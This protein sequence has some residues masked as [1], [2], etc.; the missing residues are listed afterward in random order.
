MTTDN[1]TLSVVVSQPTSIVPSYFFCNLILT[2][3]DGSSATLS[4]FTYG[5]SGTSSNPTAWVESASTFNI[6][7]FGHALAGS[8]LSSSS[9]ILYALGGV[10]ASQNV[11]SSVEYATASEVGSLS[12]WTLDRQPLPVG[13][14][15][16][17][18][19]ALDQFVYVLGGAPGSGTSRTEVL[20]AQILSALA[21]PSF[22]SV[23]FG[24]NV[25]ANQTFASG[26]F[27]YQVSAAFDGNYVRNPNGETLPSQSASFNVPNLDFAIRITLSWSAVPGAASYRIYRS[28]F[29][30]AN[31]SS[32]Y[33]LA[34]VPGNV[35]QYSDNG[36]VPVN[37]AF[38]PKIPGEL[39]NWHLTQS[40]VTSRFREGC[41]I[42]PAPNN[43]GTGSQYFIYA[44]GG[45]SSASSAVNTIEFASISIIAPTTLT[46]STDQVVGSFSVAATTM[47]SAR[48]N[49][50]MIAG[51]R[52]EFSTVPANAV[53]FWIGGGSTNPAAP[54]SSQSNDRDTSSDTFLISSSGVPQAATVAGASFPWGYCIAK[55]GDRFRISGGGS[56]QGGACSSTTSAAVAAD[57]TYSA[58]NDPSAGLVRCRRY[59]S[60]QRVG[61]FVFNCAGFNGVTPSQ[62]W[63]TCELN[64]F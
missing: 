36:T 23:D 44:A 8:K 33:L 5:T 49:I 18:A 59:S 61:A 14:Q 34:V 27:S 21:V 3:P 11:I 55:G 63:N 28:P 64:F 17:C 41:V 37:F 12:T 32:L 6:A 48:F 54:D 30:G 15:Y 9:R 35:V 26:F 47:S 1:S 20:R 43:A 60:C 13:L 7:R 19:A 16:S 62:V 2:N 45:I 46:D 29:A 25:N 58:N 10:N 40:M 53:R 56:N 24:V 38:T 50:G 52:A 4:G 31:P 51:T 22:V 57:G 42:A 39:G